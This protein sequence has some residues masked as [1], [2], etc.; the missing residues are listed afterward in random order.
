VGN[1]ELALLELPPETPAA[2]NVDQIL[3]AS[4]R[5]RNLVRQILA[6]S[7]R[8]DQERR[9]VD[10][11]LI[12]NEA[13]KLLRAIVPTTI[14]L[15]ISV[16]ADAH[17]VEA[18]PTRIHQVIINLCTNAAQAMEA[19]GGVLEIEVS[20]MQLDAHNQDRYPDTAPGRYVRIKVRD[21]GPGIDPQSMQ[22]IFDPFFTTKEVGKGT[23]MGLAVAHGIVKDHG[24]SITAYSRPGKGA[25]FYVL[26]PH[27][28]GKMVE[29]NEA[30]PEIQR[31]GGGTVLLIDDE[32]MLVDLGTTIL[33]TLGYRVVSSTSSPEALK[34]FTADPQNF[35]AVITDFTMPYLTG[36]ELAQEF[37]RIRADIPIIL[38]T[39]FS[40]QI[41]EEQAQAAGIRAFVM[42]PYN[43]HEIAATL[44]A[45]L[46][47]RQ[48][49]A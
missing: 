28:S 49:T 5:A 11:C 45:V 29:K 38:C 26:I 35:D 37:L 10:M 40:S 42:K 4:S 44:Q 1:A 27:A 6:F 33:K 22:R 30:P 18:D 32:E 7:R 34:A 19:G 39:G 16:P 25:T 12:V 31:G 9:P 43:M 47:N 41:S 2:G 36:Y 13:V 21:T 17:I 24:G 14:D 23:G 15:K 20:S 48:S 3:K 46:A 8:Q